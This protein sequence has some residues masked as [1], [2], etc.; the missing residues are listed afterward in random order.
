[1]AT[2]VNY[3]CHPT[4]LAWENRLISPDFPG[5]LREVV[6]EHTGGAPCLYLQGAAGELGPREGY[7]GEVAIA[8]RNGRQLAFAVLA[9]L[10][11][12]PPPQTALGFAGAVES[13]APLAVWERR[14]FAPPR[15]LRAE[16]LEVELPLKPMPSAGELRGRLAAT[17]DR[18]EAER[19][20]RKLRVLALVG[21]GRTC[22]M[23][24][25]VWRA[26]DSFLVGHPNEAYSHLQREL[27]RRHHDHAVA[28]MNLVNGACGY[29]APPDLHGQDIY[30][31]WQSPFDR[32]ALPLLTAACS[33]AIE[34]LLRG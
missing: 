27:R 9:A 16:L 30:Q 32:D 6:E 8:D 10:E 23:P 1:V 25:W 26:G 14:P 31:V 11:S 2:L 4:T 33:A 21:E 20:R 12:L 3:A 15:E 29:L 5:A 24:A 28:V 19:L 18:V 22:R 7:T 34:R 13:G 17:G